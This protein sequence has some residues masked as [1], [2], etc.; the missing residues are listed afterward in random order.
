VIVTNLLKLTLPRFC[1]CRRFMR[2]ALSLCFVLVAVAFL[3][4]DIVLFGKLIVSS[5]RVQLLD[6]QNRL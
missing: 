6:Q 1:R 3:A 4:T 5:Q 2:D